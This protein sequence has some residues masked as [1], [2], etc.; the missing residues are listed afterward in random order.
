MTTR[1]EL[2]AAA[3]D[4]G[5]ALGLRSVPRRGVLLPIDARDAPS[6]AWA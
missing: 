2:G 6:L 5:A 4:E 1:V 3:V